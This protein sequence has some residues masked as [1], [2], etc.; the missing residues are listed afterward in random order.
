MVKD[1]YFTVAKKYNST[2]MCVESAIRK[3]VKKLCVNPT[4]CFKEILSLTNHYENGISNGEFLH[5]MSYIIK[6][7]IT[8]ES[9][10]F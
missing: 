3:G 8:I 2:Q 10:R 4:K 6:G 9:F 7:E 5:L 1:I